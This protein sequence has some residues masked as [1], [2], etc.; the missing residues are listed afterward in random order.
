MY[1]LENVILS[2]IVSLFTIMSGYI[3]LKHNASGIEKIQLI[4]TMLGS[5]TTLLVIYNIYLSIKY[6]E[7]AED[8]QHVQHSIDNNKQ[9]FISPL[10]KI[11]SYYPESFE[12]YQS[13]TPSITTMHPPTPI[14]QDKKIVVDTLLS[15][16][17]LQSMVDYLLLSTHSLD[18]R[19]RWVVLFMTWLRSPILRREWLNTRQ[20]YVPKTVNIIDRLIEYSKVIKPE[21]FTYS[22]YEGLA[23]KF[24]GEQLV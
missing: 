24:L 3:V 20:Y 8:S 21:V 15:S 16:V 7:K 17:V 14:N 10:E 1:A 22:D 12:L 4:F 23:T 11:V 6:N 19:Q 18:R 9:S 2:L 13:M 5:L